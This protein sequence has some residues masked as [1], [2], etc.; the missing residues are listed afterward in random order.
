MTAKPAVFLDRDGTINEEINYLSRIDD[1]RFLPGAIEAIKTL[2]DAAL[3]AVVITNQAGV[4]RGYYDEKRITEIHD[5]MQKQLRRSGARLDGIY[6]C[7]HHP[8]A[9]IGKYKIDCACRK[10]KPG[11]LEKAAADLKIDLSKSFII[12]DKLSD[13]RAGLAVGCKT[14][15]VRTGYG[16]TV[17]KALPEKGLKLDYIADDVLEAVRWIV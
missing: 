17:E 7:P 3:L 13:L 1:F 12:G 9:G 14:I 8:T 16:Q 15:L 10:P 6:Y 4:A 2:N 5:F 11:M